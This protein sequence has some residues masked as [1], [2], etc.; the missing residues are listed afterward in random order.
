VVTL[1]AGW[2]TAKWQPC[3]TPANHT[4]VTSDNIN[5]L[6]L[7]RQCALNLVPKPLP[8][9]LTLIS[10]FSPTY[11]SSWNGR[12]MTWLG[13]PAWLAVQRGQTTTVSLTSPWLNVVVTAQS[14]DPAR[15]RAL[16]GLISARS[17][18][19]LA[20][21][22]SARSVL[23]QSLHGGGRWPHATVTAGAQVR[24]ILADLRALRPNRFS[25]ACYRGLWWMDTALLTV[26]APGGSA[27]TYA[28]QFGRCDEVVGGTGSA[29][30]T[31]R[32]LL[33]D[34]RQLVPDSGL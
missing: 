4:V 15:A 26:R 20:V 2:R 25:Q 14:P 33:A 3:G 13:R 10:I 6:D 11:V 17:R 31:S 7:T 29:F 24:R 18:P 30:G 34:I 16:L 1:P 19:G 12:P 28:A 23:I 21:P 32:R 22:P 9:S 27:R 8:T 5:P